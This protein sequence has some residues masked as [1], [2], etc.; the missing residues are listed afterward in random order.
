[1]KFYSSHARG[2]MKTFALHHKLGMIFAIF[3]G[4]FIGKHGFSARVETR[5]VVTHKGVRMQR[6][7][8]EPAH[9][10][11][12]NALL[13]VH[14]C[15]PFRDCAGTVTLNTIHRCRLSPH[16][17]KKGE[18][19]WPVPVRV[20]CFLRIFFGFAVPY[21][22]NS[23]FLILLT[24]CYYVYVQVKFIVLLGISSRQDVIR[25][26]QQQNRKFYAASSS[27]RRRKSFD[28][29]AK[30]AFAQDDAEVGQ[31]GRGTKGT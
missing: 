3:N 4:F 10:P 5:G 2:T 27:A 6:G 12:V 11:F 21:H 22:T 7:V 16:P 31:R 29:G 23:A 30:G 18:C 15:R 26:T 8:I 1:M 20:R 17:A 13:C 24:T 9:S 19:V 14:R 28:C 25:Q